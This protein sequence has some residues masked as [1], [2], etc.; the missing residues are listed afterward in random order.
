VSIG[1]L[2]ALLLLPALAPAA[3]AP[4]APLEPPEPEELVFLLE[5]IAIDYGL[6]VEDGA[7]VDD[8]EYR[9][10]RAFSRGLVD[11]FD[12]LWQLGASDEV[13][14]GLVELQDRIERKRPWDE[15]RTLA[16]DLVERLLDE[17]S[18]VS[19]PAA[20]PNL[21]KGRQ[22]YLGGCAACH[23]ERGRGDGF[24]SPGLDPPASSFSGAR[25]DLLSP[26]SIY[27]A[28]TFGIDGTAMPSYRGAF[29]REEIWD[30][31]F[32]VMT[33]RDGFD[34]RPPEQRIELSLA[35]G[36]RHDPDPRVRRW[37]AWKLGRSDAAGPGVADALLA[38]LEDGDELVRRYAA[39]ALGRFGTQVSPGLIALLSTGRRARPH[40][41]ELL[42]A[43]GE[44]VV[45]DLV[46]VLSEGG[47][48]EQAS[49]VRVLTKI[50]PRAEPAV[51]QL[52]EALRKAGAGAAGVH[53][54]AALGGV[55]K[56]SVPP[57]TRL[58][59]DTEDPRIKELAGRALGFAGPDA[60]AAVPALLGA[61]N[62]PS[63]RIRFTAA[64]ALGEIGD[65]RAVPALVDVLRKD[66]SRS[67]RMYCIRALA[68]IGADGPGVVPALI[69]VLGGDDNLG[70]EAGRALAAIGPS[71]LPPVI[72]AANHAD[73]RIRAEAALV[74]GQLAGEP[75]RTAPVLIQALRDLEASVAD[76]A[77]RALAGMGDSAVPHLIEAVRSDEDPR[78]R[79]Y[80]AL[81]LGQAS[82]PVA[83]AVPALIAA[84]DDP[85][86]TVQQLACWS[87][88]KIGPQAAPSTEALAAKLR[89]TDLV[90]RRT[91]AWALGNVGP[92]AAAAVPALETCLQDEQLTVRE[93][94]AEAL[95]KIHGTYEYEGQGR[96][97]R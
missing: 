96:N 2:L 83:V 66:T 8:F 77:A 86:P 39:E 51:P 28:V 45:P 20:P 46:R 82:R 30:V 47:P 69:D 70:A 57:L 13:R 35:E 15:V 89:S 48:A 17:V 95:Q 22:L 72:E 27:G 73:P 36:L 75:A 10:M 84:L 29:K 61:L 55:G 58:F 9:E 92:A 5:Y 59:E 80:A 12:V 91:A 32:F 81:A 31:S 87:L 54:A 24:A 34:P 64:I 37:A 88:G 56:A 33:L 49:A 67:V 38:A 14:E 78:A 16:G 3:V 50:G 41:E 74:L 18:V 52:L 76:S 93:E 11:H 62:D 40:A 6:A 85:E 65:E 21:E 94:A 19:L 4:P 71:A 7:V 44:A 60:N 97:P 26:H 68:T 25:M 53:V 23:G 90:L 79:G 42:A 43:L 1:I 63:S